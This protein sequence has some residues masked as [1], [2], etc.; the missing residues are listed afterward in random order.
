MIKKLVFVLIIFMMIM[1]PI[2]KAE[3]GVENM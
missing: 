3:N 1:A 2:S